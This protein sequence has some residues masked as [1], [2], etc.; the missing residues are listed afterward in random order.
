MFLNLEQ[1]TMDCAARCP[2]RRRMA[3]RG[4]AIAVSNEARE[5]AL[6]ICHIKEIAY[7]LGLHDPNYHGAYGISEKTFRVKI[8]PLISDGEVTIPNLAIGCEDKLRAFKKTAVEEAMRELH[9]QQEL[10]YTPQRF[11]YASDRV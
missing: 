6:L 5:A 1:R 11:Q 8:A 4:L 10:T 2:I 3:N 7:I 9:E